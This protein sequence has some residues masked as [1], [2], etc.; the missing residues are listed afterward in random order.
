MITAII[1]LTF[2]VLATV[3]GI[4]LLDGY[5]PLWVAPLSFVVGFLAANVVIWLFYLIVAGTANKNPKGEKLSLFYGLILNAAIVE[6][7]KLSRIKVKVSGEEIIPKKPY[8]LVANHK[9]NFD[10]FI[11]TSVIK[12]PYMIFNRK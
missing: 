9:S 4:Y 2:S 11:L 7:C 8:L 1:K 12:N 3:G 6:A 5:S 10:N